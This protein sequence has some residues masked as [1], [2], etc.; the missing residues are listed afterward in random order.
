[1][2]TTGPMPVVAGGPSGLE[3]EMSARKIRN[4]EEFAA[5]SGISRPTVSKYFQD[6]GSVRKSTREKIEAL[7]PHLDEMMSDGLVTLESVRV[8]HYRGRGSGDG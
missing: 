2:R 6:P 1:M 7:L 4:M 3:F 8:I 5:V